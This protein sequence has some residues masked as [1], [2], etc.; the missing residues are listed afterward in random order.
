MDEGGV[1]TRVR[2]PQNQQTLRPRTDLRRFEVVLRFAVVLRADF[3]AVRLVAARFVVRFVDFF[4]D[5]FFRRVL[6]RVV[7]VALVE[8]QMY[9][10]SERRR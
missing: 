8:P 5:F 1:R 9:A 10:S 7:G 6:R 2:T 4:A 3:F